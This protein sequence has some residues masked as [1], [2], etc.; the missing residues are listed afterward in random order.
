ML[1][2]IMYYISINALPII[3]YL[4]LI[5]LISFIL[6]FSIREVNLNKKMIMFDTMFANLSKKQMLGV[7]GILIRAFMIIYSTLH[8]SSNEIIIYIIMAVISDIIFISTNVRKIFLEIP[9]ITAQIALIYIINLIDNYTEQVND[10]P[11]IKIIKILLTIFLIIYAVFFVVKD[12]ESIINGK[13]KG[14]INERKKRKH[15]GNTN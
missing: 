14:K 13:K 11:S 5:I 9:N 4:V 10:D 15:K 2:S 1:Q 3:L 7:T 6:Y 8:H 12:F